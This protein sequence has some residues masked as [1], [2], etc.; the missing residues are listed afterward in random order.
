MPKRT[1]A[2]FWTAVRLVGAAVVVA[3]I[4]AQGFSTIGGAAVS[5]EHVPTAAANFFSYF[6]IL[7]NAATAVVLAWGG[8]ARVDRGRL[9]S[10]DPRGL[11]AVFAC[12]TTYML[13]TG[14]VYNTLLR[15]ISIGPDTVRWANEVMHVAAPL[16]LVLDLLVGT[17]HRRPD[18][19]VALG[20]VGF[21]IVWIVYTLVRA[22]FITAPGAN[23]PYWYPYPFL[24]PHGPA[25]WNGVWGYVAAIAAG[26]VLVAFGV[27]AVLRWR[28][29]RI[30]PS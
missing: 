30:R 6:T 21:P 24:D 10:L 4:I 9:T 25:G 28:A 3:A 16:L 26:I 14:V 17:G 5:G 8:L 29:R 18:W 7:S 19:R 12:V 13:I 22:P 11:T 15:A 23:T 27:V 1:A 2:G 20:A